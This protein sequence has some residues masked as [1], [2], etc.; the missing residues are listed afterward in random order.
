[1]FGLGTILNVLAVIAGG[2]L[3]LCFGKLLKKEVQDALM[4]VCGLC[5]LF[6]GISGTL[7]N[8]LSV[9]GG[10]MTADGSMMAIGCFVIGTFTGELL[11]FEDKMETFGRWLREKSGNGKDSA[12][13]NAFVT[14]SL[15]ICIGAMAVVGSMED[16]LTGDYSI[17]AAKSVLDL[18]IVVVFAATL[19]KGAIFAAIPVGLFQGGITLFAKVIEPLMNDAALQNLSLVGSMMIFCIGVNLVWGKKFRV[20][21]MLPVLVAA[22]IWAYL[23]F[24]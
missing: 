18:V 24:S 9:K 3:G 6:I 7:E 5:T 22:V 14:T 2:L 19:G 12:F 8:M 4:L 20:A 21:N 15:T 13:V 11:N 23:P 10:V 1:M 17:L 16:G